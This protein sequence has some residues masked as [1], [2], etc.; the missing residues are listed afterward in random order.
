MTKL[1]QFDAFFKEPLLLQ[2]QDPGEDEGPVTG[3]DH[4]FDCEYWK[5]LL[6]I[7]K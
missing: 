1:S 2:K 3:S 6:T 7:S 5:K 4:E